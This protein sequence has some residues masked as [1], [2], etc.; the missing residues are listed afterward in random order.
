MNAPCFVFNNPY[1]NYNF[2]T[3]F[4]VQVVTDLD[5]NFIVQ[6]GSS[7]EEGLQDGTFDEAIFNRPQVSI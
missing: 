4:D 3:N 1:Q 6:I 7:G 5:G 2:A